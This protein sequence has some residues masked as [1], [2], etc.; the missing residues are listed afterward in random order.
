MKRGLTI[1]LILFTAIAANFAWAQGSQSDFPS[2]GNASL[3]VNNKIEIYPNPAVD[4]INIEIRESKLTETHIVLHN[5]IGN[6]I[7][8]LPEK[9]AGNKYRL[10]VKDLPPGYYLLSIKDPANDFNRTYKFL[11]R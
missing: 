1:F 3:E 10:E 2:F 6:K 11:K 7:E 5:I 9:I 8:I 4:Y